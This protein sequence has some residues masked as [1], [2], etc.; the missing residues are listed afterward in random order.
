MSVTIS[1]PSNTHPATELEAAMRRALDVVFAEWGLVVVRTGFG[2][3]RHDVFE[4]NLL[5]ARKEDKGR[6]WK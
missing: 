2:W 6:V 1:T 5:I 3:D 4:F